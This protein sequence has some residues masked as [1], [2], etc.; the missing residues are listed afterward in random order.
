MPVLGDVLS[1]VV[2]RPAVGGPMIARLDG[3][4]VLVT[5]AI[6]GE[7][8]RAR[9]DR[10]GRGV[11]FATAI[12]VQEP[13]RDRRTGFPD[14]ACGGCI[15]SHIAYPRQLEIK[16]HVVVDAF[17]RIGHLELPAPVPVAAS[18]EDGY[19]MRARLHVRGGRLGFF[20]EGTHDICDPRQSQQLLPETCD[21]LE[22]L[23][24][25]A[26]SLGDIV[27]EVE[28]SENIAATERVVYLETSHPID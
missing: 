22:R 8:V 7:R 20:R 1:L 16:S 27:R 11:A 13:S 9:L 17:A 4:V 15:Y 2:D 6:P 14:P 23:M 21:V 19:R 25:S 28:L 3:R 12:E 10:I 5:G 24:A 26:R 18:R